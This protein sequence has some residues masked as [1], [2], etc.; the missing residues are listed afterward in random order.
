MPSDE[1]PDP[2]ELIHGAIG[3]HPTDYSWGD[4]IDE[5]VPFEA[6]RCD[7]C[8]RINTDGSEYCPACK[9]LGKTVD[10]PTAEGP[11]MD[12]Y[13]GLPG[14]GT[15]PET[16]SRTIADLPLCLVHFPELDTWGLALTGGGMD[17]SW[18]IA[19]AYL[20]LGYVPPFHLS[21]LPA[22]AG[23]GSSDRDRWIIAGCLEAARYLSL[24]AEQVRAHL[25]GLVP[26]GTF[27]ASPS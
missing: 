5:W 17:L 2:K 15:D 27:P 26:L 21:D 7:G 6:V 3:T 19:E 12:Y 13:Y 1:Y 9:A 10:L 8:Q 18:E 11:M 23:R 22:M 16:A 4:H 25:E 24:R 20:R 14:F